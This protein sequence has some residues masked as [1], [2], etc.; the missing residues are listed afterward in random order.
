VHTAAQRVEIVRVHRIDHP[1]RRLACVAHGATLADR[2]CAQDFS[3]RERAG[4]A[5]VGGP[6]LVLRQATVPGRAV[7]PPLSLDQ[8][9]ATGAGDA[10]A[11]NDPR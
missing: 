11:W 1:A 2:W 3:A 7:P 10:P 9:L 8:Q 6:L 4:A 5:D